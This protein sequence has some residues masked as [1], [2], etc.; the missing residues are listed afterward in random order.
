ML[1]SLLLSA[2][3]LWWYNPSFLFRRWQSVLDMMLQKCKKSENWLFSLWS[4]PSKKGFTLKFY[5]FSVKLWY[6]SKNCIKMF[7][8]SV[9]L[10]NSCHVRNLRI[11]TL[12]SNQFF[13][14]HVF[15][16]I[17]N[18]YSLSWYYLLRRR[19]VH[20]GTYCHT[21]RQHVLIEI[22]E[23][24]L[25]WILF[26]VNKN[27]WK[28]SLYLRLSTPSSS[29]MCT[30]FSSCL[31]FFPSCLL[32]FSALFVGVLEKTEEG[33]AAALTKAKTLY[34]SCTNES[35]S[36]GIRLEHSFLSSFALKWTFLLT[37]IKGY[38]FLIHFSCR[39]KL[40]RDLKNVAMISIN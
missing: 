13:L 35:E 23:S 38:A 34:K 26:C 20:V 14:W 25:D 29:S 37:A 22:N 30:L 28:A 31:P 21:K 1:L 16:P 2:Q 15:S 6:W 7:G 5:L 40:S 32:R 10:C 3:R 17:L 11:L 19:D 4:L 8:G 18:L 24:H 36:A 39:V 9:K 27:K 33:E 12:F